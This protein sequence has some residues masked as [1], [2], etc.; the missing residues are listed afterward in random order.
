M[1]GEGTA[2]RAALGTLVDDDEDILRKFLT[3]EILNFNGL[4][5]GYLNPRKTTDRV[6]CLN[7]LMNSLNE[8]ISVH[9]CAKTNKRVN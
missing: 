8:V 2:P 3:V 6:G 9:F 4:N 7:T 5:Y 1:A